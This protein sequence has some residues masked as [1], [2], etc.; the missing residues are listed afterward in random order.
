[1]TATSSDLPRRGVRTLDERDTRPP[2][3]D[4]VVDRGGTMPQGDPKPPDSAAT[5]LGRRIA[6]ADDHAPAAQHIGW[7]AAQ[8]AVTACE[9]AEKLAAVGKADGVSQ[10][11]AV[12]DQY[13]QI[14]AVCAA[15]GGIT[16]PKGPD[17]KDGT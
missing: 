3:P 9:M 4:P 15:R 11:L 8:R 12:A 13:R 1:M 7:L 6:V 2:A 17:D 16:A 10:F 5:W 14:A